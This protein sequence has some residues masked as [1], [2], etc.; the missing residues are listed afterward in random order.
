MD[1]F[2]KVSEI[3]KGVGLAAAGLWAAWTFRKLQK[4]RTAELEV[5][6]LRIEREE[7][8]TRILRQQPQ[9]A[10]QLNVEE[11]ASPAQRCLSLL[12]VSVVLK[13]EGDQ[14]LLVS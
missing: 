11:T 12:C 6:K 9:L 1:T 3:V 2:E 7:F 5:E 8:R 13:N 14:N 10:I 4:A